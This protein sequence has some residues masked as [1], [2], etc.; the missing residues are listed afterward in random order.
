[1]ALEALE[2]RY[3][4]LY[5]SSSEPEI[6]AEIF[7]NK[8]TINKVIVACVIFLNN[9]IIL[10]GGFRFNKYIA[11][12]HENS[13]GSLWVRQTRNNYRWTCTYLKFLLKKFIE[14]TNK[15]H[16]YNHAYEWF[17][18][19][20]HLIPVGKL[21]DFINDTN[22]TKLESTEANKT[23]ILKKWFCENVNLI[24]ESNQLTDTDMQKID[25]LYK[26]IYL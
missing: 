12:K 4:F 2:P 14:I 21:T 8:D 26:N 19:Y 23:Y 6:S 1:M 3:I 15:P 5:I 18:K 9:A 20:T 13:K 22:Y 7:D 25:F 11:V 10:N 17:L 24:L 16:H